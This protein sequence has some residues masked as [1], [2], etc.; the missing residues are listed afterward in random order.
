[1]AL[2]WNVAKVRTPWGPVT[3]VHW[4]CADDDDESGSGGEGASAPARNGRGSGSKQQ[5]Q[6]AVQHKRA[7]ADAER[8]LETAE[9]ELG[10]VLWNSNSVAADFLHGH[11]LLPRADAATAPTAAAPGTGVVRVLEL[12]AGVGCLGIAMAIGGM[13]VCI[14]DVPRLLPLLKQNLA[15]NAASISASGRGGKCFAADLAWEAKQLAPAIAQWWASASARRVVVMCD[16]LYGNPKGWPPLIRL[17][18][19]LCRL[20][21]RDAGGDAVEIVNFCEQRVPGVEDGFLALLAEA[22][23]AAVAEAQVGAGAG[24]GAKAVWVWTWSLEELAARSEMGMTVRR[25]VIRRQP[26]RDEPSTTEAAAAMVASRES[27]TRRTR[28]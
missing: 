6:E 10:S 8:R 21:G 14:T 22:N 20:G 12:G 24:A 3:T 9:D 7:L 13:D 16:A 23:R 25:A 1:M 4:A 11:I 27:G 19:E 18:E 28:D 15:M 5:A 17:L 2:T 26:A